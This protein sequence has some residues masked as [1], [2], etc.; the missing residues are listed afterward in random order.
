MSETESNLSA[1]AYEGGFFTPSYN[2]GTVTLLFSDTQ[3]AEQ[4]FEV[5]NVML[6][7]KREQP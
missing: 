7:E 2:G 5:M 6:L 3:Q 4:W 1:S